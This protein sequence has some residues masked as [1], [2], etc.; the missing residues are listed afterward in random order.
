MKEM[1]RNEEYIFKHDDCL[2]PPCCLNWIIDMNGLNITE[3]DD[4]GPGLYHD[5]HSNEN[6]KTNGILLKPNR[7][8]HTADE[9]KL[10]SRVASAVCT[11]IRI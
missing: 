2:A 8:L 7:G 10:S 4:W 1:R 9:T 3:H 11:R 6:V 5:D